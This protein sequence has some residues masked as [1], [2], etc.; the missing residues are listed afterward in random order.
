MAGQSSVELSIAVAAGVVGVGFLAERLLSHAALWDAF[1]KG[2]GAAVATMVVLGL[3]Q[4]FGEVER[5]TRRA[6]PEAADSA[7]RR[8]PNDPSCSPTAE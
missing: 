2:C 5:L 8:R 4:G 7:L 6:F 3:A 1:M